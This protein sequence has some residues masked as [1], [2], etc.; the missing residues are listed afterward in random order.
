VSLHFLWMGYYLCVYD[1]DKKPMVKYRISE[2]VIKEII[3]DDGEK[4]CELD[5]SALDIVLKG[6]G[7]T[8]YVEEERE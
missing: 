6:E 7:V 1:K 3:W 2:E 4:K 8:I 5:G